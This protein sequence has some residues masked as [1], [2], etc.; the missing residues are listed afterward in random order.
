MDSLKNK[1]QFALKRYKNM[2]KEKKKQAQLNKKIIN[3]LIKKQIN[4]QMK[5]D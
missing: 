3:F 2:F 5:K 1:N 4:N